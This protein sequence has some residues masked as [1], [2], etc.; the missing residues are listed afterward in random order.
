LGADARVND[1][2]TYPIPACLKCP[3]GKTSETFRVAQHGQIV[4]IK[5]CKVGSG[6]HPFKP[7]EMT[8]KNDMKLFDKVWLE[9]SNSDRWI[10][11]VAKITTCVIVVSTLIY[12]IVV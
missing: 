12:V 4:K 10:D 8:M 5:W 2:P 6:Y 9:Q 1:W 7:R 11:W 3:A